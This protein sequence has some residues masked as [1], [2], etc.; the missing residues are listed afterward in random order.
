MQLHEYL[1]KTKTNATIKIL[2]YLY[3]YYTIF[4]L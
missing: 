3:I 4:A 1:C 2:F